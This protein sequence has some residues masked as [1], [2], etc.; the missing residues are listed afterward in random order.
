MISKRRKRRK[1]KKERTR[2]EAEEGETTETDRIE[3]AEI[4]GRDPVEE[5]LETEAGK[6]V[7]EIAEGM[8]IG[9]AIEEDTEEMM[10]ETTKEEEDIWVTEEGK[11]TIIEVVM[12]ITIGGTEEV[13]IRETGETIIMV[14]TMGTTEEST[15]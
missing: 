4:M 5:A 7:L 6:G 9:V 11:E 1:R 8:G 10:T 15:E 3:E 14:P 2:R 13:G 12:A